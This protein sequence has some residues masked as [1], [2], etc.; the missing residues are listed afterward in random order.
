[1][2]SAGFGAWRELATHI[3]TTNWVIAGECANFPI[4]YHWR[5]LPSGPGDINTN[6]WGDIEEYCQ[7]WENSAVIRQRIEELNKASAHI[8]L[9]LEYVPQNLHSFL[10]TQIA[11]GDDNAEKAVAFVGEE[12]KATNKCLMQ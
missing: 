10:S 8:A 12:L 1:M 4:M 7:Y 5:I 9:F 6:D 11:K 3:M 2:G